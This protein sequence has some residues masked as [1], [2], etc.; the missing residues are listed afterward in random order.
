VFVLLALVLLA[1]LLSA[2]YAWT[3][4]QYY[5]AGAGTQVA[6]YRGVQLD[7]PGIDLSDPYDYADDIRLADLPPVFRDKVES[8]IVAD[9][10]TDARRIIADLE[11]QVAQAQRAAQAE[12]R[13]QARQDAR[14]KRAR[15]RARERRRQ[16]A[17][18]QD[19]TQSGTKQ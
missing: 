13:A 6:I 14:E 5:V 18:S 1:G 8:G 3:R 7:L 12:Q 17:R 2:A 19:Q 4:T 11:D 15:E 10:L 16:R 9:S